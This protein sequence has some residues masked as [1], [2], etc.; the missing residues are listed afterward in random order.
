MIQS[1]TS[2]SPL[3]VSLPRHSSL[4]TFLQM[5][6]TAGTLHTAGYG[7]CP[8]DA[9]AAE[10]PADTTP[11]IPHPVNNNRMMEKTDVLSSAISSTV[12]AKQQRCHHAS[13]SARSPSCQPMPRPCLQRVATVR[14]EKTQLPIEEQNFHMLL[15]SVSKSTFNTH[16]SDPIPRS[17]RKP[18]PRE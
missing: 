5:T 6:Y 4:C 1:C 3:H 18:A 10:H 13:S 17:W 11:H 7:Q 16:L 8:E 14:P 12:G 9:H 2:T 15:N